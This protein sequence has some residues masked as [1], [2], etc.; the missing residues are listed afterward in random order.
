M[1]R[2]FVSSFL[3]LTICQTGLADLGSAVVYHASVTL[4][5]GKTV[6]G[7][8]IVG[9]YEEYAYLNDKGTNP[10]C[11]D[12]GLMKVFK[13]V[14]RNR[15]WPGYRNIYYPKYFCL[16]DANGKPNREMQLAV[17]LASDTFSVH[18]SE[19][20]SVKF[21]DV[22]PYRSFLPGVESFRIVTPEMLNMLQYGPFWGGYVFSGLEGSEMGIYLL[23]FNE[24]YNKA[25][26][27]RLYKT[28]WEKKL[29]VYDHSEKKYF[30]AN[31][32]KDDK[33][34]KRD[35][36]LYQKAREEMRVWFEERNVLIVFDWG[37]C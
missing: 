27:E 21:H 30:D 7:Y 3:I 25:E 8:F 11:S 9:G 37:T 2:T 34:S 26:I 31:G 10:Y 6:T 18:F 35:F 17:A 29:K 15:R 4:K 33:R 22:E 36:D 12:T 19:I 14:A 28:H 13:E 23:N 5:S 32:K 16:P 20:R 24:K 1:L